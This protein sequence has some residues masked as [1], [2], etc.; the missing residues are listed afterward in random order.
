F[1]HRNVLVLAITISSIGATTAKPPTIASAIRNFLR[2]SARSEV[3]D[4]GTE[5]LMAASWT[6]PPREDSREPEFA[7]AQRARA[8]SE[9]SIMPSA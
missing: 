4:L 7:L 6:T 1:G 5:T 3:S 2:R 9:A 8:G